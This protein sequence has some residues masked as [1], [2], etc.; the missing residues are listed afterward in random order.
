MCIRDSLH[1]EQIAKESDAL[2]WQEEESI[3]AGVATAIAEDFNRALRTVERQP[4]L[5][6][7]VG[8]PQRQ[9][10]ES[11]IERAIVALLHAQIVGQFG[12]CGAGNLRIEAGEI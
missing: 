10:G 6:G 1:A 5:E 11:G 9:F 3:A 7:D 4:P 8:Q 12:G 2:R